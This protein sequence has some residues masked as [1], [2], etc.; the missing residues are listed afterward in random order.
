[1]MMNKQIVF[2]V[3]VV[4]V[5]C[6]TTFALTKEDKFKC[7]HR[8][9]KASTPLTTCKSYF[10]DDEVIVSSDPDELDVRSIE[11]M[12]DKLVT[13]A[14]GTEKCLSRYK[15]TLC[16]GYLFECDDDEIEYPSVNS[17]VKTMGDCSI[18]ILPDSR[19][20]TVIDKQ[21]CKY[22]GS[23]GKKH[24]DHDDDDDD[25]DKRKGA[26]IAGIV[27]GILIPLLIVLSATATGIA[28]YVYRKRKNIQQI[29]D[30][31]M[32]EDIDAQERILQETL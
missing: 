17:C 24:G 18:T 14:K 10:D 31:E 2:L 19:G 11:T 5:L 15:K 27:L 28:L 20:V 8:S 4:L 7:P 1:M 30:Q 25:D 3:L 23:Y 26:K 13:E 12:I 6:T 9:L 21:Q 29:R 32:Y 16:R 22:I